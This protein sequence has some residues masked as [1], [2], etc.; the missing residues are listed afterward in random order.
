MVG[1]VK[2][3]VWD[4]GNLVMSGWRI[5]GHCGGLSRNCGIFQIVLE[6]LIGNASQ[7]KPQQIVAP[8]STRLI[9]L[10]QMPDIASGW[11]IWQEQCWRYAFLISLWPS[12]LSWHPWSSTMQLFQDLKEPCPLFLWQT[13]YFPGHNLSPEQRVFNYCLSRARRM[14]ECAFIILVSHWRVSPKVAEVVVKATCILHNLF[15]NNFQDFSLVVCHPSSILCSP[16]TTS[17]T[18]SVGVGL[19]RSLH[20]TENTR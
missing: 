9:F 19:D 17:S 16:L 4:W 8:S 5:E 12:T 1:I 2:R 7:S 6:Q 3:G 14:M 15:V 18:L 10:W 20:N 13:R 11:L